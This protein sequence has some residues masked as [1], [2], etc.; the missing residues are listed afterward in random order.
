MSSHR[1]ALLF[2]LMSLM[3]VLALIVL[4]TGCQMP[5]R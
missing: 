5:L 3:V 2:S 1:E 4:L